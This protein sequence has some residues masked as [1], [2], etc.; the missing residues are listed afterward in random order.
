MNKRGVSPV[1]ATVLLIGIVIA[2]GVIVF[3]WFSSFTQEAIT[4]FNGEN[5]QLVCSDP[6]LQFQASYSSD[7]DLAFS[8]TGNVPI[9]S[10]NVQIQGAAGTFTTQD[11]K[12]LI[13][14]WPSS[15]LKTGGVFS[16]NILGKINGANQL[17]LIPILEGTVSNGDQKSFT[18]PD[19]YGYKVSVI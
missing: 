4:K 17:I 2:L 16:G 3:F 7:G 18:C 5:I 13:S 9:Y 15:G 19:Q 11:I 10:F 1:I 12:S 6:S 8:N 14:N